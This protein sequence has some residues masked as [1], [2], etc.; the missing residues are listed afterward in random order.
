MMWFKTCTCSVKS[1]IKFAVLCVIHGPKIYAKISLSVIFI[2][3]YFSLTAELPI[4]LHLN[5]DLITFLTPES[6]FLQR[7]HVIHTLELT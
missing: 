6:A 1:T 2:I 5:I 3:M 4:D 7:L